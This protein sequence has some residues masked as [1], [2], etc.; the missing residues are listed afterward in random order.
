MDFYAGIIK[1]NQHLSQRTNKTYI[2]SMPK[3]ELFYGDAHT[4]GICTQF[5]NDM[6]TIYYDELPKCLKWL[7]LSQTNYIFCFTSIRHGSSENVHKSVYL[8]Q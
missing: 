4:T 5:P 6:K 8:S 2:L 1:Y 3:N 7:R